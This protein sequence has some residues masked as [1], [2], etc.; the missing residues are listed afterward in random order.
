MLFK[1]EHR[2]MLFWDAAKVKA[3]QPGAVYEL[4][5]VVAGCSFSFWIAR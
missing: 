5:D 4:P 1:K 2:V 3:P